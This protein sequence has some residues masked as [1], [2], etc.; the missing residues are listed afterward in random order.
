M[1]WSL[2]EEQ[3]EREDL[4]HPLSYVRAEFNGVLGDPKLNYLSSFLQYS[5]DS[6]MFDQSECWNGILAAIELVDMIKIEKNGKQRVKH[7]FK[8]QLFEDARSDI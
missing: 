1:I 8:T 3:A 6:S 4:L 2:W 5:T 7:H